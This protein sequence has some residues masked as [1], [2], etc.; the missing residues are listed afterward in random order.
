MK[1]LTIVAVSAV[2]IFSSCTM[3]KRH[4]R[5]GYYVDFNRDVK[6]EGVTEPK[7]EIQSNSASAESQAH[8]DVM[9]TFSESGDKSRKLTVYQLNNTNSTEVET[10]VDIQA[11]QKQS[12]AIA[13]Y[14]QLDNSEYVK[15]ETGSSTAADPNFPVWAYIIIALFIPPLA[16]AL[17]YGI[18]TPFWLCLLFT[19]LGFVPGLIYALVYLAL[20]GDGSEK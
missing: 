6:S 9:S 13:T 16:V 4:Y 8:S 1:K 17:K 11:I 19:L 12:E 2:L 20:A 5:S 15:N 7:T 14:E 3:E 10:A 18:H